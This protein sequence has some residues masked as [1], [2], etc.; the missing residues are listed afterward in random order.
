MYAHARFSLP[1]MLVA[2]LW[3]FL[4]LHTY[5]YLKYLPCDAVVLGLMIAAGAPMLGLDFHNAVFGLELAH[6]SRPKPH[7]ATAPRSTLLALSFSSSL[8][9][10]LADIRSHSGRLQELCAR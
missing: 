10:S 3:A 4:R 5:V 9:R 7:Y 6:L 1:P 2:R 8:I